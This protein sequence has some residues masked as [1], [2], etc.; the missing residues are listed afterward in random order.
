MCL[1][2][3]QWTYCTSGHSYADLIPNSPDPLPASHCSQKEVK[4]PSQHSPV[5]AS[6][7][8][9]HT[10]L[11]IPR[12]TLRALLELDPCLASVSVLC[13]QAGLCPL[14]ILL[15]SQVTLHLGASHAPS[16]P[17]SLHGGSSR[18][19]LRAQGW[20]EVMFSNVPV[21]QW[22]PNASFFLPYEHTP[23]FLYKTPM[24]H[25]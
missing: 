2:S 10:P 19:P 8:M 17:P 13:S 6:L 15:M 16:A 11:P 18:A 4:P 9:P 24:A 20:P 25:T 7:C 14:L 22:T 1:F 12:P 23:S 3:T 5:C 21:T